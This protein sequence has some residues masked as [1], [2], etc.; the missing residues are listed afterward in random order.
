MTSAMAFPAG[1]LDLGLR[2]LDDRVLRRP[3]LHLRLPCHRNLAE[4][5]CVDSVA[6]VI[7]NQRTG[8]LGSTGLGHDEA[9]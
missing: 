4:R 9:G 3:D 1:R 2:V 6:Q 5:V 7:V 8:H